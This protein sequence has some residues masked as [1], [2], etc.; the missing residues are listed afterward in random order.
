MSAEAFEKARADEEN[1][2]R[3]LETLDGPEAIKK[4]LAA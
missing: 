3:N 2:F 4:L 1:I